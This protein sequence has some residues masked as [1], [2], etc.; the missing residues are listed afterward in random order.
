M[1]FSPRNHPATVETKI[2]NGHR[3]RNT[4]C[5]RSPLS[6][7]QEEALLPSGGDC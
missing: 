5:L 1:S 6:L 4:P 7:T 2:V 3:V